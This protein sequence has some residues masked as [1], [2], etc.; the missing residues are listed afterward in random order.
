MSMSFALGLSMVQGIIAQ[1]YQIEMQVKAR[2]TDKRMLS[3]VTRQANDMFNVEMSQLVNYNSDPAMQ[4]E[5]QQRIN[6]ARANYDQAL[7]YVSSLEKNVDM[8]I[9]QLNST[10]TSLR[11]EKEMYQKNIQTDIKSIFGNA[12]AG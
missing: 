3:Q 4:F 1:V 10:L 2:L 7:A 8:D 9:E 5:Q 11:S 12:Y 6:M